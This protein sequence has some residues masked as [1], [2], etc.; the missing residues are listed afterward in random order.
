[1]FKKMLAS[2]MV[3]SLL[4]SPFTAI[5]SE[6][7]EP[8]NGYETVI[9]D[10]DSI[11]IIEEMELE[12]EVE[13]YDIEPIAEIEEGIE[14][15]ATNFPDQVLRYW[16]MGTLWSDKD[17]NG[18][19][20]KEEIENITYIKLSG[21]RDFTGMEHLVNLESIIIYAESVN[22]DVKLDFSV[23]HKL[24]KLVIGTDTYYDEMRPEWS[25]VLPQSL[26]SLQISYAKI[27]SLNLEEL[28]NLTSLE[29]T[30]DDAS[31]TKLDLKNHPHLE[32]L[33]VSGDLKNLDLKDGENLQVLFLFGESIKDKNLDLTYNK[34]LES[35]YI[36]NDQVQNLDVSYL[37][38]LKVLNV[39]GS[40]IANIDITGCTNLDYLKF[41]DSNITQID[42]STNTELTGLSMAYTN[43]S[44]LDLSNHT[45]LEE[46][47]VT[48]TKIAKLD[49]SNTAVEIL[50]AGSSYLEEIILPPNS[51]MLSY[52]DAGIT[53]KYDDYEELTISTLQK[54][55]S[56]VL[57]DSVTQI[58]YRAFVGN[59]TPSLLE[60]PDK[61]ERISE[62][63][64]IDSTSLNT[65]VINNE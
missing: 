45:K 60:F 49:L 44:E 14:I 34:N 32:E 3:I 33:L 54:E 39:S 27:K 29:I 21:I 56:L 61:I 31:Q 62:L 47:D 24:E 18:W 9:E 38:K 11:A 13:S 26:E 20:S 59:N 41:D 28:N 64:I 63:A 42:I 8:E 16:L 23:F 25:L 30:I 50:S 37:T 58:G 65:M 12:L 17:G 43:I 36:M 7:V 48:C 1:M 52:I 6:V 53:T 10:I 4:S 57:P 22:E 2:A 40:N 19:L 35:A 46:L 55:Y 15:N 5:A 51:E